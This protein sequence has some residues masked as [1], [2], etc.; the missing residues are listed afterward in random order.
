[1]EKKFPDHQGNSYFYFKLGHYNYAQ[2]EDG[3]D[4]SET[5]VDQ[6]QS[7]IFDPGKE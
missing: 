1:M 5:N 2:P 3:T 7:F 6:L 4:D